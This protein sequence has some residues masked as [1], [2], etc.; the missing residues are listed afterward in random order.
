MN[1]AI[2]KVNQR[3]SV[4]T[5]INAN[6]LQNI[7]EDTMSFFFKIEGR[8]KYSKKRSVMFVMYKILMSKQ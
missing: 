4:K 7:D 3:S 5:N 2:Y 8:T 6:D 1:S